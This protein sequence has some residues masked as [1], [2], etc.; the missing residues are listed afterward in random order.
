MNI[1]TNYQVGFNMKNEFDTNDVSVPET[2][3]YPGIESKILSNV[4]EDVENNLID[5]RDQ[6]LSLKT[7]GFEFD[8]YSEFEQEKTIKTH[9][10]NKG[11][12][13]NEEWISSIHIGGIILEIT[14]D[15]VI[16]ECLINKETKRFQ[17]RRFPKLLFKDFINL[18]IEELVMIRIRQKSGSQRIDIFNARGIGGINKDDFKYIGDWKGIDRNLSTP[19]PK[20]W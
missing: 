16:I 20:T 9:L 19:L 7:K 18:N 13:I 11:F 12:I 4:D 14:A 1:T 8:E 10:A 6:G 17:I 15:S 5:F 3:D 2:Q